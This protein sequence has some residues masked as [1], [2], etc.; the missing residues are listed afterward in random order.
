MSEKAA[1]WLQCLVVGGFD[2]VNQ[3]IYTINRTYT[4]EEP[5]WRVS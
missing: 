2:R 3:A 5:K 4:K 1:R